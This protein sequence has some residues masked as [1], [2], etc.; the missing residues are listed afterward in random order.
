M[1]LDYML[2]LIVM[3]FNIG[4]IVA[5]VL[6]FMVG[7]LFLGHTGE[8]AGSIT[9]GGATSTVDPADELDVRFMEAPSCCGTTML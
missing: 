7:A 6:G 3:T 5:V 9:P 1:F 2:M 4:I 8:R